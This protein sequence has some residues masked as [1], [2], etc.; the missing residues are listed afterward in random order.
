MPEILRVKQLDFFQMILN[1]IMWGY[2]DK[3]ECYSR[4]ETI[5]QKIFNSHSILKFPLNVIFQ[6][7][8]Q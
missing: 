1:K 8:L 2:I 7:V 4:G 6:K 3:G 5:E